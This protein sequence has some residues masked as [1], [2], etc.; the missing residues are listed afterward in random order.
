MQ[1]S[2]KLATRLLTLRLRLRGGEGQDLYSL[3]GL[4]RQCTQQEIR[5]AYLSCARRLHPD[6]NLDE[7]EKSAIKFKEM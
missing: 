3:L 2:N 1:K 5:Q 7:Q 6:K 4:S